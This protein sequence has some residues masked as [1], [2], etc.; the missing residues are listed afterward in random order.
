MGHRHLDVD[1]VQKIS[2]PYQ[3]YDKDL[4]KVC[5]QYGNV[6]DA[7]IPNRRSKSEKKLA[8]RA[9]H[10]DNGVYG[11]SNSYA[12]AVM[13]EFQKE[14]SKKKFKANVGI[15]LLHVEDQ[16]E[17]KVFWVRAKEVSGWIP[18]FVE[19]DEE[20]SDTDDEIRDEELYDESAGLHNHATVEGESHVEEVSETIFENEQYQAHKK[21]DLNVGQNDI[22]LKDPFNIYDLLNKKQDNIIRGSS[23]NNLKYPPRFTPTV[24]TKVQSNA[25]KKLKIKG[26][27]CLQNIHDEKVA[28]EVKKT[29]SLSNSK[30]DKE[31]SICSGHFKKLW[32][33]SH[34]ILDYQVTDLQRIFWMRF[35]NLFQV[36]TLCNLAG[37]ELSLSVSDA[38]GHTDLFSGSEKSFGGMVHSGL[39]VA[40]LSPSGIGLK[41][42]SGRTLG[43]CRGYRCPPGSD[44][45]SKSHQLHLCVVIASRLR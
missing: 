31:E 42:H 18:D 14:A 39:G 23:S 20:E 8:P 37:E 34:T 7:F 12:H 2:I 10:K 32:Q 27:E 17:G 41:P 29:C 24:A 28:Y 30:N 9:D 16:D 4:W 44:L 5:N 33:V 1:E 15:D 40:G 13:I 35:L 3:F 25:F 11:Y 38:I 21:D 22:R 36:L 6:V 43:E 45:C 19:D 26:Y